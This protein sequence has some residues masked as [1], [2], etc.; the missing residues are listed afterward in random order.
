MEEQL[1]VEKRYIGD[2]VYVDCDGYSIILTT[3]NGTGNASNTI[4]MGS[5]CC[6]CF[7]EVY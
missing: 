2:S 7:S 6:G 3:E 4:I 5:R 1:Q